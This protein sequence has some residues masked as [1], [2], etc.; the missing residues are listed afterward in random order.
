MSSR[1]ET[2]MTAV[3]AVL[4]IFVFMSGVAYIAYRA[5]PKQQRKQWF[6]KTLKQI[7]RL[8][9]CRHRERV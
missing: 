3:V 4:A 8:P 2:D 7:R 6:A 1:K 9:E 5:D